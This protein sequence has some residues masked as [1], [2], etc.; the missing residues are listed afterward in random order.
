MNPN[1]DDLDD[2]DDLNDDDTYCSMALLSVPILE[3]GSQSD[4]LPKLSHS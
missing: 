1:D 2:L 3:V 4:Y